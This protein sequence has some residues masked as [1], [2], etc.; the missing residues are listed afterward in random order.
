MK[1]LTQFVAAA[2]VAAGAL[3]LLPER[4][5]AGWHGRVVISTGG[6]HCGPRYYKP[7]RVVCHPA[8]RYYAPRKVYYKPRRVYY[9]PRKVY[10]RPVYHGARKFKYRISGCR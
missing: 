5:E 7:R 4:A 3:A 9:A 8:P 1:R 10:H 6:S 2:V